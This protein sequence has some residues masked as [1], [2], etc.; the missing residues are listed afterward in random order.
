M[1]ETR[2]DPRRYLRP[3]YVAIAFSIAGEA[4]I[5]LVFGLILFPDGNLL[6]K[7]LWALLY[8]GVGMGATLGAFLNMLVVNRINRPARSIF[9]TAL[10]SALVLGVAC[11][12]LCLNLDLDFHYFGT[13][14][15]PALFFINGLLMSIVGG[16]MAGW[17]LFTH[18]GNRILEKAGL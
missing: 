8:C 17:L 15:D 18:N 2:V 4:F 13:H 14:T 12:L 3:L 9:A 16:F 11:N 5:L 6:N 10:L 7:T 1:P